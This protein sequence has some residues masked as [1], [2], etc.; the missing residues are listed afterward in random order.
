MPVPIW[1]TADAGEK[2]AARKPGQ[3]I[4]ERPAKVDGPPGLQID[5]KN[6]LK[7]QRAAICGAMSLQGSDLGRYESA[8]Q[9][10]VQLVGCRDPKARTEPQPDS[11]RPRPAAFER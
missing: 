8:P 6:A 1:G 2:I 10:F 5:R 7:T 9:K 3:P 11:P 4:V